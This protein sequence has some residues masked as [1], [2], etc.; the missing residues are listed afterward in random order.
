[1]KGSVTACIS[2]VSLPRTGLA[3]VKTK[4]ELRAEGSLHPRNKPAAY[5]HVPKP[6]LSSFFHKLQNACEMPIPGPP[7][8]LKDN[9]AG[10]E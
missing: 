4:V 3:N 8:R 5:V 6:V 10:A 7:A 2:R 1:M 9:E